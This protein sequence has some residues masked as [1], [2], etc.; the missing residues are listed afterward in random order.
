MARIEAVALKPSIKDVSP[1]VNIVKE[2]AL[3]NPI[4]LDKLKPNSVLPFQANLEI[5][6][7]SSLKTEFNQIPPNPFDMGDDDYDFINNDTSFEV[8]VVSFEERKEQVKAQERVWKSQG[9]GEVISF[10]DRAAQ[11]KQNNISDFRKIAEQAAVMARLNAAACAPGDGHGGMQNSNS[12]ISSNGE[13]SLSSNVTSIFSKGG[14]KE[15]QHDHCK[16]CGGDLNDGKCSKCA[17]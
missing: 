4:A 3:G 12:Q 5:S 11:F 10:V 9:M 7:I 8:K 16:S 17:A 1:Q 14:H 13:M 2:V 6:G 15:G